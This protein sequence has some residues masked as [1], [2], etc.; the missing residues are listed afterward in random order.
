MP[1]FIAIAVGALV[2]LTRA[3]RF[4]LP[5]LAVVGLQGVVIGAYE[6]YWGYHTFATPY[7]VPASAILCLALA[8]LL[9]AVRA[10]S[11]V[12][13]WLLYGAMGLA[14]V[15]NA[16]C[17]T[18]HIADDMI[19]DWAT[20]LDTV[21]M[22]HQLW[23]LEPKWHDGVLAYSSQFGILLREAVGGLRAGDLGTVA[24]TVASYGLILLPVA[25][26]CWAS[27]RGLRPEL[28]GLSRRGWIGAVAACAVAALW[29]SQLCASTDLDR[30]YQSKRWTERK[31]ELRP[32][33]L[34]RG[35]KHTWNFSSHSP[36]EQLQ[37]VTFLTDAT[38]I[39]AGGVVG[40]IV[41][42][43]SGK[44]QRIKLKAGVDTAD[45]RIDRPESS[46]ARKHTSPV[47][48]TAWSYRVR[49][50]SSHY[51][52]AR[53]YLHTV[54][55]PEGMLDGRVEVRSSIAMGELAVGWLQVEEASPPRSAG[56]RRWLADR[57]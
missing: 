17:M 55:L 36:L 41:V 12:G 38:E 48:N 23:M 54:P 28:S 26:F 14:M 31:R 33:R 22:L 1:V 56:R 39:K 32:K 57:W 29:V 4:A 3:P 42:H 2:W 27:L 47:E 44:P 30:D 35:E 11:R 25:I 46:D 51:Y 5:L 13:L 8:H 43:G 19:G 15:R 18:R 34:A 50:A 21:E 16:W 40:T 20:G 45:F 53:A 10:R 24:L 49:D 9:E 52:N 37:V 6:V 7:L